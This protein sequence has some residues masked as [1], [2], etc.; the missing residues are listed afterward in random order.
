MWTPGTSVIT[1]PLPALSFSLSPPICCLLF[2]FLPL[3][4]SSHTNTLTN[5]FCSPPLPLTHFYYPSHSFFL[6]HL[7]LCLNFTLYLPHFG[8]SLP[9]SVSTAFFLLLPFVRCPFSLLMCFSVISVLISCSQ[10]LSCCPSKSC[11]MVSSYSFKEMKKAIKERKVLK[12]TVEIC[13]EKCLHAV[14][15]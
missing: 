12:Q 9:L 10:T 5:T 4:F 6:S 8:L 1:A 11:E 2:L 14:Y 13:I 7:W 15:K 3:S